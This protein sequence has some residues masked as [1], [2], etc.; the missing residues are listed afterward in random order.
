M[1]EKLLQ[2]ILL[3]AHLLTAA[4]CTAGLYM[5]REYTRPRKH[6]I[7]AV[8]LGAGS[9]LAALCLLHVCGGRFGLSLPLT[10]FTASA[11]AVGGI[12]GVLLLCGLQMLKL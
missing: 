7:A 2:W 10:V 12:P 4:G 3:P 11:A 1:T 6:R 5:L 8:L 9:G